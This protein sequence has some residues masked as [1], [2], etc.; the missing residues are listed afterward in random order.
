MTWRV[1][2]RS[3]EPVPFLTETGAR[4]RAAL[5]RSRGADPRDIAAVTVEHLDADG[6]HDCPSPGDRIPAASPK[7]HRHKDRT[8]DRHRP[9]EATE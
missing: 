8:T 6:W 2:I 9:K 7:P 3:A 5:E 1:V 4:T